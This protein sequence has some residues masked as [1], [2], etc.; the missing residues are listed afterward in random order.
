MT[1]PIPPGAHPADFV[2]PSDAELRAKGYVIKPMGRFVGFGRAAPQL[3]LFKTE[4]RLGWWILGV[5]RTCIVTE[6]RDLRAE[7][8]RTKDVI[9][10]AKLSVGDA[11]GIIEKR[12]K[13]DRP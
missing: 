1:H 11:I 3:D 13:G 9:R 12:A 5:C 6:V 2:D 8:T 4:Y 7:L 10:R